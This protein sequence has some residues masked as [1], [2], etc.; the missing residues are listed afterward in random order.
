VKSHCRVRGRL[1]TNASI[2]EQKA[3]IQCGFP[4]IGALADHPQVIRRDLI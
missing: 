1:N 3:K 4:R 2:G